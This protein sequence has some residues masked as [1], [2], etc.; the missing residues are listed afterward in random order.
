MVGVGIESYLNADIGRYELEQIIKS[1]LRTDV[2]NKAS[3]NA[4]DF[5]STL[6]INKVVFSLEQGV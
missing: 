6:I 5:P 2:F 3:V 1:Q 4:E